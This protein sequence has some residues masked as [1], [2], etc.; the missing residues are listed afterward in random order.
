MLCFGILLLV[1]APMIKV[2]SFDF[3]V[4]RDF[5]PNHVR[6]DIVR[7][8]ERAIVVASMDQQVKQV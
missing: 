6:V 1:F 7:D 8:L 4:R 2:K 3:V 5:I